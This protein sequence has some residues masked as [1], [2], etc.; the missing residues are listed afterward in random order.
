MPTPP[1]DAAVSA[2]RKA[3]I[4]AALRDGYAPYGTSGGRGAS[5]AR[6][7]KVLRVKRNALESWLRR[8]IK[9]ADQK[10][11]NFLPD[12]SLWNRGVSRDTVPAEARKARRWLLTAAQNDTA[13]HSRFWANL[14]AYAAAIGA[15]IV[16]GP[17]TYQLGVFEDHNARNGVFAEAVRS[18]LRFD[19][20]EC[21]DV[22]FC[23]EMNTLPT[24]VR[25]LSGLHS[26]TRGRWAVFPH[27]KIALE[28]VPAMPGK[29]PAIMM[30]TGCCTVENYIKKKAG[31]KAQ[32]HHVIGATLVEIDT[33]GR[34]F[35]RQIN[36]TE[37]GAFQDLDA[38]V[39]SGKVSYGHR[40]AA[41]NP[42][43]IHCAVIDPLVAKGI[44]GLG[45]FDP[46]GCLID[47]LR[48]FDQFFHDLFHGQSINHW[49]RDKP[50]QRYPLHLAGKLDV[51]AEVM[52][53]AKF[54]RSTQRSGTR[55][56]V[57]ESNH[58]EWIW[59]WLQSV[60]P[61]QDFTNAEAFHR[62]SLATLEAAARG[63]ENFSIF[64]HVLQEADDRN[65]E[66]IDFIPIGSSFEICK[67]RGGI[68]CGAHGHL[69]PNGSRGTTSSLSK[70]S[71]KMNKGH[72]HTATIHDGIF[73]AG[74]CGDDP[75]LL[76]GPSSHTPSLIV[77]YPNAKRS[78][79]TMHGEAWRA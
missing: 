37:D 23:A 78:I 30:T 1:I 18:Y 19:R 13:I 57:V 68:E 3:A 24:A 15:Q 41:I 45:T 71:T 34:A 8:Q 11:P 72:D 14:K 27:A 66:G 4:E 58:D 42:G 67:D 53:C 31:L 12:W 73:S 65:L 21:G 33:R 22:L 28:T 10:Q 43:D 51:A 7:A 76:K 6:A 60:D 40:V 2:K 25:P 5:V 32:F 36:A 39:S 54:L 16:V 47:V 52:A 64:R 79:I 50:F 63:D 26:Y 74:V 61:R 56:H 29:L 44:W 9:L 17:F 38:K 69:G 55:T 48:P 70:T 20:T 35:C 49:Q 75:L 62:W 77:T 46:T 59:R